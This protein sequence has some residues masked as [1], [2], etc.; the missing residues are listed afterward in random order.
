MSKVELVSVPDLMPQVAWTNLVRALGLSN[1]EADILRSAMVD[2]RTTV[3]ARTLS[4]SC[5]TVHT[6]RDRMYRKVGVASMTQL[7][8]RAF[9]VHLQLELAEKESRI[10]TLVVPINSSTRV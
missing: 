2:D 9:A 6:Y 8:A 10:P 3:I 4:L 1:R 7:V 5:G